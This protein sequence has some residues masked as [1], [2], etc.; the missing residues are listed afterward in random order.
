MKCWKDCNTC[1]QFITFIENWKVGKLF[2]IWKVKS[3]F[4]S[5]ASSFL[6]LKKNRKE[7]LWM[8]VQY[9][10]LSSLS[11]VSPHFFYQQKYYIAPEVCLSVPYDQ[12]ADIWSLGI[13][14]I[15]MADKG[16]LYFLLILTIFHSRIVSIGKKV[17]P[18]FDYSPTEAITMTMHLTVPPSV[19]YPEDWSPDFMNLIT[20][21]TKMDVSSRPTSKQLLSHHFFNKSCSQKEFAS[22]LGHL[23]ISQF[24]F[25]WSPQ[26][27]HLFSP[28]FKLSIFNFL[29]CDSR[30]KKSANLKLPKFVL[31]HIFKMMKLIG[32]KK[33][34]KTCIFIHHKIKK[35]TLFENVSRQDAHFSPILMNP[36]NEN[37]STLRN[38]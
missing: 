22:F 21:C 1:I 35:N 19:L 27:H 32:W 4:L 33:T 20:K 9:V 11:I 28:T 17:P 24:E 38:P 30:F 6:S 36:L 8:E 29:L 37:T 3:N 5:L 23:A 34:C 25:D 18:H 12:K 10:I 14:L 15:E 16:F 13:L 7:I 31:F 26:M 2:L